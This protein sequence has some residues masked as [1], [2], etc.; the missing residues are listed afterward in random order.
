M[1]RRFTGWHMLAVMLGF[2]GVVVA[3]NFAMARYAIGTFGGVVV[4]NSYVASQR[5]NI[6]LAKARAQERLGWQVAA[7]VADGRRLHITATGAGGEPVDGRITVTARHRL[8]RAPDRVVIMQAVS[9]GYQ[10][11]EP[12]P[13]GRWQLMIVLNAHGHIARFDTEVRA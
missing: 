1:T 12:L 5:F 13:V 10:S 2:F 11:A 8:G 6:W 7:D 4:D 9:G 3:V